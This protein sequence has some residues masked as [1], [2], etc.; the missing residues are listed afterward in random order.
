MP[1]PSGQTGGKA[2]NDQYPFLVAV[3]CTEWTGHRLQGVPG[4]PDQRCRQRARQ[5]PL[6]PVLQVCRRQ[7]YHLSTLQSSRGGGRD[8]GHVS[9]RSTLSSRSADAKVTTCLLYSHRG[10]GGFV[11]VHH[12]STLSSRSADAKVTTCLLYSHRRGA[13]FLFIIGYGWGGEVLTLVTGG[14][15]DTH[16]GLGWGGRG[17]CCSQKWY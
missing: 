6:H 10:G 9:H 12:R 1:L 16:R 14:C 8:S 5:P 13:V 4:Q 17:G 7:G 3:V 2:S 11:F 15:F